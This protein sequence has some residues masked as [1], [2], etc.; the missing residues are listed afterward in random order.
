MYHVRHLFGSVMLAKGAGLAAVSALLGH[1][2]ISTT[3]NVYVHVMQ[4]AKEKAIGLLP[5]VSTT[6]EAVPEK[7][8]KLRARRSNVIR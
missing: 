4:G 2:S 5:S 1:K 7:V 8:V 6:D 3:A